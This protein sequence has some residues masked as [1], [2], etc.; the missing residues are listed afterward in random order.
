MARDKYAAQAA[1][2]RQVALRARQCQG[3]HRYPTE[4]DALNRIP[5]S[6]HT[7]C[8]GVCGSWHRATNPVVKLRARL[9]AVPRRRSR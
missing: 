1:E 2:A 4:A 7:Y 5:A 8:C 9:R 6:Q 3:K